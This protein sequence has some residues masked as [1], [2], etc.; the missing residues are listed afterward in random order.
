MTKHPAPEPGREKAVI[1]AADTLDSVLQGAIFAPLPGYQDEIRARLERQL[2]AGAT[3]Y[4]FP[5]DGSCIQITGCHETTI[6]PPR[7]DPA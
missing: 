3:L 1:T 2:N 6:R 5:E 7:P 4:D